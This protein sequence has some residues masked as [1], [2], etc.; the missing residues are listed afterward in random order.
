MS[1]VSVF[2]G[3][4]KYEKSGS[5]ACQKCEEI[6]EK[7]GQKEGAEM[8]QGVGKTLKKKNEENSR[9]NSDFIPFDYELDGVQRPIH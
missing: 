9:G 4:V 2:S 3:Q 6:E 1:K 5:N 8:T 7:T